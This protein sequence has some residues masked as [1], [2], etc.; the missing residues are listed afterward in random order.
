MTRIRIIFWVLC[1]GLTALWLS[2]DPIHTTVGPFSQTRLSL[3]FYTGIIAMGV[4]SV[5]MILA[6][7]SGTLESHVGGLDKSYRLHKWLGVAA[8]VMAVA[9]WGWISG[10][11]FFV[12]LGWMPQPRPQ[13][14]G[15]AAAHGILSELSRLQ[16]PARA[17]GQ[18]GFYATVLLVVLALLR[19][20][21]YR[22]FLKTHR[23]LAVV[24]LLLVFHSVILMKT[25]Y[26]THP[27]SWVMVVLMTG[28]ALAALITL[29]RR[30][31]RTHRAVGEIDEVR[32]HSDIGILQVGVRLKD[33]W[34][35]HQ[36][37]QFAFVKFNDGED[38]HP[39]TISSPWKD[40]GHLTFLIKGL[41][42]YTRS[43]PST[44]TKGSLV[45]VEGPYGRFNFHDSHKR[46][47]WVS[48]GIGITPF[49]A[50]MQELAAKPDGKTIDLFHATASRDIAP[51]QQLRVL[52]DSAHVL[53]RVWVAAE[54]GR[55]TGKDIRQVVPDWTD[56]DIW[57]CGPV[58]FGHELRK[59]FL[60]AGLSANSFHQELF[61][62]R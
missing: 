22:W 2:A 14:G 30:V 46:Q 29:F 6:V 20:F 9:H 41:G 21:P 31:G 42:D 13:R 50:R 37:G 55:M 24:Y 62:L 28:G 19:W 23:L 38:P 39:F 10:Q 43:L 61:H 47:I 44:V 26:W 53:L 25:A 34:S 49:V 60:A 5:S 35:G 8:L 36:P 4:M 45:T 3:I 52:A 7:R 17:V 32:T 18:W 12:S 16:G 56:A 27:I 54:D 1:I 15:A 48:A 58:E 51:V 11:G 33:G 40:D 57:F 59:D